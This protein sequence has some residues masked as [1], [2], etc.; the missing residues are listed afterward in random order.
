MAAYYGLTIYQ[1]DV[2]TAFLNGDLKEEI[3]M[4]CP[5][6]LPIK[7]LDNGTPL[8]LHLR[9][10]LYGLKQ[11]SRVWY[12]LIDSIFKFLGFTRI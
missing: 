6:G 5:P 4:T 9:K 8:V 12:Q 11:A 1:M 10:S 2:I 3:Y 7:L